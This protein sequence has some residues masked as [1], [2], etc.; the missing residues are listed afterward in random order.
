MKEPRSKS[1]IESTKAGYFI[2]AFIDSNNE[3][4]LKQSILQ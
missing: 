1:N 2:E 4:K 3:F